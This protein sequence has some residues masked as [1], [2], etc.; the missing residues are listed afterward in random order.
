[1]HAAHTALCRA[2]VTA[3]DVLGSNNR[4]VTVTAGSGGELPASLSGRLP[5]RAQS[6]ARRYCYYLGRYQ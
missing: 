6:P 2:T 4:T 1:M 3:L 5:R